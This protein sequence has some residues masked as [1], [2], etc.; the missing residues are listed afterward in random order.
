MGKSSLFVSFERVITALNSVASQ[1][2]SWPRGERLT[3]VMDAFR[4]IARIPNIIG[5]VDGTFIPIKAP[6][7][8]SEV[9]VTRKCN[10][11]ITLQGICEPCLKFTDV[12]VGYP[13]SVSDTRIFR[14]SDI[15]R[16]IINDRDMFIP[17]GAFIIGDK[18]YPV[19]DWCVPPYID[20]GHLTPNQK[21]F[22]FLISKTRQVIERSFGLLFGR[23]RRLKYLDMNRMD[24]I[25]PTV[26]AACVIHNICIDDDLEETLRRY[27]DEGTEFM[28]QNDHQM[29][30]DTPD[31]PNDNIQGAQF[32]DHLCQMLRR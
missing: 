7:A 21:N 24:L 12:F 28:H 16:S 9:Y 27:E 11:A 32:R 19:L 3:N 31:E 29:S 22:N 30:N 14:N 13:G 6:S 18:A 2:I 25:P 17:R 1:V 8:D 15:Y 4:S 5:A 10:Y 26:L 20:R 23:F